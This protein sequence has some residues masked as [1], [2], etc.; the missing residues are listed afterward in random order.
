MLEDLC[1]S[2]DDE[3]SA[4]TTSTTSSTVATPS[5]EDSTSVDTVISGMTDGDGKPEQ[6]KVEKEASN[7]N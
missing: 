5:G 1:S 4:E 2:S 3:D 7:Y 6:P